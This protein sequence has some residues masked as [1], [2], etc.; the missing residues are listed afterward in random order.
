MA[1]PSL[2]VDTDARYIELDTDRELAFEHEQRLRLTGLL[3]VRG[4]R[5][6][7]LTDANSFR[8]NDRE[9]GRDQ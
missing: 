6:N 8:R 4:F 7:D 5:E 2:N 3:E 1:I 9:D